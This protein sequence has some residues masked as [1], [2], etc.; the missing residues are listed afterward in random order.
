MFYFEPVS[1]KSFF[2]PDM[3]SLSDPI[4]SGKV[5]SENFSNPDLDVMSRH[6]I[7]KPCPRIFLNWGY[8]CTRAR[9][10]KICKFH[11]KTFNE[12]AHYLLNK[13]A[14]YVYDNNKLR[15]FGNLRLFEF[16][17]LLSFFTLF[18]ALGFLNPNCCWYF[19]CFFQL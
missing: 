15:S 10:C 9:P 11:P 1:V 13:N 4:R 5:G 16:G 12:T 2:G 6:A 17:S 8:R 19:L 3:T 18:N 14:I 7:T